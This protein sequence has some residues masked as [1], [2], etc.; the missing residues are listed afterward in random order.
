[1][2]FHFKSGIES[3]D[4]KIMGNTRQWKIKTFY[5]LQDGFRQGK[6]SPKTWR[7]I[8]TTSWRSVG[9]VEG[10]RFAKLLDWLDKHTGP[11]LFSDVS[12]ISIATFPTIVKPSSFTCQAS[13]SPPDKIPTKIHP[14]HKLKY[15]ITIDQ[16]KTRALHPSYAI[17][18]LL[19]PL[20][21]PRSHLETEIN[22]LA[23]D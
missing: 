6:I 18:D 15:R 12:L 10:Y 14:D 21:F 1:M 3:L 11:E 19:I 8:L 4:I 17:N 22:P 5:N 23:A 13:R 16:C 20:L 7:K 9:W 2:E